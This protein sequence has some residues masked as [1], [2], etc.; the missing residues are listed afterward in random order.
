MRSARLST[1]PG[2]LQL[3]R[4]TAVHPPGDLAALVLH[5]ELGVPVESKFALFC[6]DNAESIVLHATWI[7]WLANLKAADPEIQSYADALSK[8]LLELFPKGHPY[9]DSGGPT[10]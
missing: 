8:K 6:A 7:L 10:Q 3:Q 1:E 9:A 5:P 2:Q 4:D